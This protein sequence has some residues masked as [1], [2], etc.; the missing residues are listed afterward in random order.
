MTYSQQ[1]ALKHSFESDRTAE[2]LR[3]TAALLFDDDEAVR[4]KV[5]ARYKA[6]VLAITEPLRR[7]ATQDEFD[8][9]FEAV[10]T[11][12]FLTRVIRIISEPA[13]D[14]ELR[15]A[16]ARAL[17]PRPLPRRP[18]PSELQQDLLERL[19]LIGNALGAPP[20]TTVSGEELRRALPALGTWRGAQDL[21]HLF[22][23][24]LALTVA[25]HDREPW[26]DWMVG[27]LWN[28]GARAAMEV[29]CA[30]GMTWEQ[31]ADALVTS[32]DARLA[33]QPFDQAASDAA[34]RQLGLH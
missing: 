8:T 13:M 28:L 31:A 18:L 32:R 30:A 15:A 7:A 24:T 3:R 1:I 19:R 6:A 33:A 23:A 25:C 10:A 4:A 34:L 12:E 14:E 29:A 21:A 22:A 20:S 17:G 9:V 11:R 16:R 5:V 26:R 2:V 27:M